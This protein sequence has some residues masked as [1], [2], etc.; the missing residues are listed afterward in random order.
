MSKL[1]CLCKKNP[2]LCFLPL[3][4]Q[5]L[6]YTLDQLW[7]VRYM[8]WGG[9]EEVGELVKW[10][11]VFLQHESKS[12]LS[13]WERNCCTIPFS[14]GVVGSRKP[15]FALFGD[16]VNT[17]SRMQSNGE[18]RL[19]WDFQQD[20]RIGLN[21]FRFVL[22]IFLFLGIITF[23]CLSSGSFPLPRSLVQDL[24]AHVD[25]HKICWSLLSN[26]NVVCRIVHKLLVKSETLG[27]KWPDYHLLSSRIARSGSNHSKVNHVHI[28]EATHHYVGSDARFMWSPRQVSSLQYRPIHVV[29][30]A[31]VETCVSTLPL[32]DSHK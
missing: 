2:L 16:T 28:S 7:V 4:L 1:R 8:P 23:T 3:S 32:S 6:D 25:W 14:K 17:A 26:I 12:T 9:Y 15:Q 29:F 30:Q 19:K 5:G 22:V 10:C 13:N 31:L 20:W 21:R 11:Q 18:V 27:N 24:S